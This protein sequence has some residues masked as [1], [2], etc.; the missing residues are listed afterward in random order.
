MKEAE[1]REAWLKHEFACFTFEYFFLYGEKWVSKNMIW[2]QWQFEREWKR[3]SEEEK[4]ARLLEFIKAIKG[5]NE[6]DRRSESKEK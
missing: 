4:E 3:K 6:N 5:E 1:F 2:L